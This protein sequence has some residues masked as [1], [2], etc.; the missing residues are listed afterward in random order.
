MINQNEPAVFND[1]P[2]SSIG[3][4]IQMLLIYFVIMILLAICNY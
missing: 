1:Q 4:P 2:G 3:E